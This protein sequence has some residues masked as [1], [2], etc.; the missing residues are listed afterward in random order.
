MQS[1]LGVS[2]IWEFWQQWMWKCD[3]WSCSSNVPHQ[4]HANCCHQHIR[5]VHRVACRMW[6]GSHCHECEIYC[7]CSWY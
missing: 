2:E 7:P 5:V 3:I 1:K 4:E 6:L